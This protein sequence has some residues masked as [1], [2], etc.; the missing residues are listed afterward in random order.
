MSFRHY[1]FLNAMGYIPV[2]FIYSICGR[3]GYEKNM[4]LLS[5]GSSLLVSVLF[6]LAGKKY[7]HTK[8]SA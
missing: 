6:W 5:F 8:I 2:C 7:L 1:F 3:A 4:F